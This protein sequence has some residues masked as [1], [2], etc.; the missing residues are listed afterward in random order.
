MAYSEVE[1]IEAKV[2]SKTKGLTKAEEKE[3]VRRT[4]GSYIIDKSNEMQ[5]RIPHLL[6]VNNSCIC[7]IWMSLEENTINMQ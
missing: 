4:L 2:N 6:L 7:L 3:E 1:R 5:R